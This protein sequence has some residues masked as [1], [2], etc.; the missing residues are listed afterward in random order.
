MDLRLTRLIWLGALWGLAADAVVLA[1]CLGS[2]DPFMSPSPLY[3]KDERM[4]L[5]RIRASTSARMLFDRGL[6]SEP[7]M[8]RQ[9]FL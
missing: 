3:I 1:C 7:L 8:L 9:L 2:A 4:F 6:Q 5:E